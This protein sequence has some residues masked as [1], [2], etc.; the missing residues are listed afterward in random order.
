MHLDKML[1][2]NHQHL[3]MKTHCIALHFFTY[4]KYCFEPSIGDSRNIKVVVPADVLC[5][6]QSLGSCD[7]K[8]FKKQHGLRH[9]TF[10]TPQDE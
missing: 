5:H 7:S 8:I 4:L 2:A 10:F 6:L 3:M 9:L 1:R